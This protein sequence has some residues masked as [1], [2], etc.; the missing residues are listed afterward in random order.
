MP[1]RARTEL[2]RLADARPLS[3][4]HPERLIGPDAE[5]QILRQVLSAD[6]A[7][8]RSQANSRRSRERSGANGRRSRR[9][10]IAVAAA[11]AVVAVAGGGAVVR[12]A[13]A[14]RAAAWPPGSGY[15]T[16]V[17]TPLPSG[18]VMAALAGTAGAAA[19]RTGILYVRTT[20]APGTTVGGV[21]V[22]ETWTR[23]ESDREKF[24]G[25]DGTVLQDA[26]AVISHGLRVRRFTDYTTRTWQTDS[27]AVGQY[28][29]GPTAGQIV[30]QLQAPGAMQ[31]AKVPGVRLPPSPTRTITEVTVDRKPT[32]L[33]TI[34][35]PRSLA[36]GRVDF[37]PLLGS[38]EM[39]PGTAGRIDSAVIERVWI[40]ATSYL[41]VRADA[42]AAS[43][44]ILSAATYA[45]LSPSPANRSVI[46]PAPVPAGF[47]LTA[48]P[49][50]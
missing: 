3:L 34:R 2:D 45:W 40:D 20:F 21:A 38:G 30:R 26:S 36:V 39:L 33:V 23:G 42:A 41:P 32:I 22:T 19:S 28:G 15:K 44:R 10:L 29:P 24:L 35:F 18:Q 7:G 31:P 13:D 47:R 17:R 43:G 46:S 50:H 9:P 14:P 4:D 11:A 48:E 16:P 8:R 27:I 6:R 49:A 25:A 5:D 1:M 37:L 12:W